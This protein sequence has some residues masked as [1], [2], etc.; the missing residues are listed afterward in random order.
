MASFYKRII[1]CR[2][3]TQGDFMIHLDALDLGAY[4]ELEIVITLIKAATG[5]GT[6]VLRFQHAAINEPDAYISL[7]T[8]TYLDLINGSAGVPQHFH[9]AYFLRWLRWK[10]VTS[11]GSLSSG[12]IFCVDII[13][14][15]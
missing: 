5:T 13:A 14:K 11:S 15:E 6:H 2:T 3:L 7:N 10:I 8:D 12:A 4:R 1:D 9:N